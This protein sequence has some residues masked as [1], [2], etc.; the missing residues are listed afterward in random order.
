MGRRRRGEGTVAKGPAERRRGAE[1]LVHVFPRRTPGA[2]AEMSIGGDA[3]ASGR[4]RDSQPLYATHQIMR[5]ARHQIH[6]T[7]LPCSPRNCDA[8]RHDP[9]FKTSVRRPPESATQRKHHRR[10]RQTTPA[11]AAAK[12]LFTTFGHRTMVMLQIS[13]SFPTGQLFFKQIVHSS[14]LNFR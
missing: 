6:N 7:Q 8:C 14:P 11:C 13:R 3:P 12:M 2:S 10:F 1:H 5:A 9:R 4:S